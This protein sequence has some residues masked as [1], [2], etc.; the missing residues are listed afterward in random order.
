MKV[1]L[2]YNKIMT[3]GRTFS[4]EYLMDVRL[5]RV[6]HAGTEYTGPLS[7]TVSGTRCQFW[8]SKYTTHEVIILLRK[9]ECSS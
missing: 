4:D 6:T 1:I 3:L 8:N 5:C 9:Y 2:H 7:R